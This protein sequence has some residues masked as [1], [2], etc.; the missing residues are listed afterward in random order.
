MAATAAN[1]RRS[2]GSRF[3]TQAGQPVWEIQKKSGNGMKKPTIVDAREGG[4]YPSVTTV[5]KAAD[6]PALNAWL[7]EQAVIACLTTERR[8]DEGLDSFI[9]RVLQDDRIQDQEASAAADKGTA[10]HDAIEK[11]IKGE[12]VEDPWRPY[13]H[14]V[15]P[16]IEFAGKIVWTEKVLVG[17][18]YAGRSDILLE[19]DQNI[20]LGDFKTTGKLPEKEA[21]P[22]HRMQVAAYAKTLGNTADKHII[23]MLIY[24]ST[25]TTEVRPFF[26]ENWL[27]TYERGFKPLF[28]FWQW[29][30]SYYPVANH[31]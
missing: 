25:K 8:N 3:Y 24:I 14:A 9:K 15:M 10:I 12:G 11:A 20:I 30:N 23:T 29:A 22:E 1:V 19:N 2:D 7:T 16:V 21:W 17:D 6:R 31:A 27:D 13:V 5:L 18:G 4:W 28:Q 26:Q